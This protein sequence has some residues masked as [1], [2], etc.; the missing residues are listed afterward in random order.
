MA[1]APNLAGFVVA[2][3]VAFCIDAGLLT[4]LLGAGLGPLFARPISIAAAMVAGWLINRTWTYGNTVR[5]GF[6]EFGRYAVVASVSTGVNYAVFVALL[7]LWPQLPPL[8]ALVMATSVSLGVSFVGYC[9][10][11]FRQ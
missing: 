10:F 8:A 11:V 4:L 6:Q 2:G 5:P 3:S 1:K 7:I 9:R